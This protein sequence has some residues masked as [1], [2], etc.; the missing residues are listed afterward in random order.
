MADKETPK[1]EI[2]IVDAIDL[3]DNA[4]EKA[5]QEAKAKKAKK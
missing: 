1:K 2:K 4:K 5:S 3:P